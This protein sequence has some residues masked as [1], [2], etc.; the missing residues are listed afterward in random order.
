M[1]SLWKLLYFTHVCLV[2]FLQYPVPFLLIS[3]TTRSSSTFVLCILWPFF[4]ST[5][6]H[7]HFY[8]GCSQVQFCSEVRYSTST[9]SNVLTKNVLTRN[10]ILFSPL[11]S[12]VDSSLL[13][14]KNLIIFVHWF[15]ILAPKEY[16]SFLVKTIGFFMY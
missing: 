11:I 8:D 5:N 15:C 2:F 1:F 16:L 6:L 12:L 3:V 4:L 10:G 9:I 14:Y 13:I 7:T